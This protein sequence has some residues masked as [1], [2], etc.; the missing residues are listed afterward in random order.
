[1]PQRV[2]TMPTYTSN[3]TLLPWQ[4]NITFTLLCTSS[5]IFPYS[6]SSVSEFKTDSSDLPSYTYCFYITSSAAAFLLCKYLSKLITRIL[7][8]IVLILYT[9]FVV[10]TRCSLIYKTCMQIK[11]AFLMLYFLLSAPALLVIA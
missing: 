5:L 11:H 1:M 2:G 6:Y 4:T 7:F 3:T 9:T 10:N 8:Y